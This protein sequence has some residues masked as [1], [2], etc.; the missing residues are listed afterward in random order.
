MVGTPS[1]G[2]F[3]HGIAAYHRRRCRCDVCKAAKK[4]ENDRYRRRREAR[5]TLSWPSGLCPLCGESPES[6]TWL[7]HAACATSG[8]RA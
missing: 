4:R 1:D 6:E 8:A 2:D 3:R 5:E 7:R